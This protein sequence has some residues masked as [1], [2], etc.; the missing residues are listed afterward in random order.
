[1]LEGIG[2]LGNQHSDAGLVAAG[3]TAKQ[4]DRLRRQLLPFQSYTSPVAYPSSDDAFPKRL[5]GLAAMLG[6]GLPLH[7]VVAHR[8]RL[9]RHA[10][11]RG[12]RALRRASADLGLAPRV[13]A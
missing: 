10:H 5:A 8:A 12:R 13:P 4:V 1:M 2:L 7:C 6:S 11:E 3:N 9:V